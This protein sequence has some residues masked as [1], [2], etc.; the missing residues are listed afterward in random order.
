MNKIINELKIDENVT[1]T[2]EERNGKN[3]L[4][5]CTCLNVG[6]SS[7][8]LSFNTDMYYKILKGVKR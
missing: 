8:L 1:I 6:E 5:I 7:I 2:I 4:Y 3:G